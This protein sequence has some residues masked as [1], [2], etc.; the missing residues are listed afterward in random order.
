MA[1]TATATDDGELVEPPRLNHIFTATLTLHDPA[2]F[3]THSGTRAI[4]P[5]AAGTIKGPNGI[6]GK[7]WH[8]CDYVTIGVDGSVHLDVHNVWEMDNGSKLYQKVQGISLRDSNDPTNSAIT[9]G[10]TFETMDEKYKY[11]NN[12]FLFGTGQKKGKEITVYYYAPM[13]P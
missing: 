10:A 8:G 11:L 5:I 1:P 2:V 9:T 3:P 13:Q 12:A 6:E 4:T 7:L